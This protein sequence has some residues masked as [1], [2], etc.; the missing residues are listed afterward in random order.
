L[1]WER[2]AGQDRQDSGSVG[3]DALQGAGDLLVAG[4]P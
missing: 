3:S 2:E 4:Q 1:G